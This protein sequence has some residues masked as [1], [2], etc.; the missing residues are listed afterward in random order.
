MVGRKE[1]L[2]GLNGY[3]ASDKNNL[4]IVYGRHGIGK[5]TL[6]KEFAGDKRA[7]YF[8]AA[9][10]DR[11]NMLAA[12]CHA[13]SEQIGLHISSDNYVDV[14]RMAAAKSHGTLLLLFEEFQNIVKNDG[15]FMGSIAALV[16]G[17]IADCKVMVI[18][19]SPSVAWIENSM[20]K[21]IGEAAFSI[22]VFMKLRELSFADVV[23]MYPECDVRTALY[24]YAV[25]GGVPLY[26]KEWNP[27][28]SIQSN[29][30]RLFL[31]T[32]GIF[33]KEAEY[34]IKAEFRES[35]V[36]NILLGCLAAGQNKLNEIHET[37]GFGRDKISV[38]LNN[39]IEREIAEK[40][41]SYDA[42][43]NREVRKGLYRVS[44]GF[45]SFWYGLVHPYMGMLGIMEPEEFYEKYVE[46]KLDVFILETFIKV[47]AEFMDIMNDAGRLMLKGQY[48]GRWY[49][50]N[51]NIHII[52]EDE[53]SD[54]VTAQV[55]A[56]SRPVDK[57]DYDELMESI[58]L[59]AVKAKQIF[60]FS[61]SGFDS[62]LADIQNNSLMLIKIEDL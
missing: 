20:V 16:R 29:V 44:D 45:C 37:T 31:R 58:E 24:M 32:G 34:F 51:G 7:I 6:I 19:T 60:M 12:Y 5:S 53:N 57:R 36:Y 4:T 43:G 41:F 30:C 23:D 25:T 14:F 10:A 33:R 46:D 13:V 28:E 54:A 50:K 1:Q 40:I 9:A 35:S 55:Y 21:A 26:L 8:E 42:G 11:E 38:Y 59:A 62:D 52:Y 15:S 18:L 48:K 17:A 27:D 56:M 49:G 3:Y 2:A 61:T 47:A 39:L 22:N